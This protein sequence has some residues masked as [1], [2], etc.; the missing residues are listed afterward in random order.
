MGN[1]K[2]SFADTTV[3]PANNFVTN[4]LERNELSR[5]V[6]ELLRQIERADASAYAFLMQQFNIMSNFAVDKEYRVYIQ[7]HHFNMAVTLLS[8][9][10]SLC[11][12]I[13]S[14][15]DRYLDDVKPNTNYI[16][17]NLRV[18]YLH[19][20]DSQAERHNLPHH[21][22]D[23]GIELKVRVMQV[24]TKDLGMYNTSSDFDVFMRNLISFVFECHD[25]IQGK[26]KADFATI[27]EETAELVFSWLCGED[28]F[29]NLSTEVRLWLIYQIHYFISI[30]TTIA[31]SEKNPVSLIKLLGLFENACQKANIP[32]CHPSNDFYCLRTKVIAHIGG[33]F[34]TIAYAMRSAVK[35][36]ASSTELSAES[37]LTKLNALHYNTDDLDSLTP[38]IKTMMIL[39]NMHLYFEDE[40]FDCNFQ[41]FA[42]SL[43]PKLGMTLELANKNAETNVKVKVTLI[44]NFIREMK[45]LYSN[46]TDVNFVIEQFSQIF[47]SR[48]I[49]QA[50]EDIF[51]HEQNIANE[52][53][54]VISNIGRACLSNKV[55]DSYFRKN[56]K[57]W[58]LSFLGD[59]Q[60]SAGEII[61]PR[62]VEADSINIE[63][64]YRAFQKLPPAGKTLVLKEMTLNLVVQAGRNYLKN[65]VLEESLDGI[66]YVLP[67][68]ASNVESSSVLPFTD[69]D[70]GTEAFTFSTQVNSL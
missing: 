21:T 30:G 40:S 62:A 14:H 10:Q 45:A 17:Q 9:Q 60:K 4:F 28:G 20:I 56:K 8:L 16:I 24:I 55:V 63:K 22:V 51:F 1:Q 61:V 39:E 31:F 5:A 47:D 27:E 37:Y 25:Y 59:K 41:A 11:S 66:P 42:T 33:D 32:I 70:E 57:S 53:N 46:S 18:K 13:I 52:A 15:V 26:P 6:R 44:G 34:D 19:E 68:S 49:G 58:H 7:A 35:R 54:F 65:P 29:P 64:F 69:L 50:I 23:H 38:L 2:S 43:V 3:L 48:S 67:I 12:D 36:Q